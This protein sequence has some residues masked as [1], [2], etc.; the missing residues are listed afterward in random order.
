MNDPFLLDYSAIKP[1]DDFGDISMCFKKARKKEA[2]RKGKQ[3]IVI[4]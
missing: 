4:F 3:N 2:A 1:T